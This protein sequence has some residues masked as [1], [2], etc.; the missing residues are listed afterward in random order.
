VVSGGDQVGGLAGTNSG[1]S[2]QTSYSTGF[3]SGTT[4]VG[5]LIGS[6]YSSVVSSYWNS[7]TSG[8]SSG[9]GSDSQSQSANVT[10]RTTAQLQNGSVPSGFSS[11]WGAGTGLYPYLLWQFAAGTTPQ[12]VSGTAHL[13]DNSPLVGARVTGAV[14]GTAMPY[15]ASTGANGYYY[16]VVPQGS[17][18]SGSGVFTAIVGNTVKA[19]AFAQGFSGSVQNLELY[20][21]QLRIKTNATALSDVASGLATAAGNLSGSDLVFTT[22]G[23]VLTPKSNTSLIVRASND[24]A[25]DQN[26]V[27][28]ST[29]EVFADNALTIAA[30]GS[31]TSQYDVI[32]LVAGTTFTN[33]SGADAL[34]TPY[35][36]WLIYSN[37]PAADTRGG[38][39]YAFKQYDAVYGVT[40]VAQATGNGVLY[41]VTPGTVTVALAGVTKSYDG[42]VDAVLAPANF[43]TTG[44][45]D[46]D[47][48][49]FT[50]GSAVYS[51]KNAATGLNVTATGVALTGISDG[52]ATVY[53]Y[54]FTPPGT[55]N[56]AGT[57][58]PASI[59]VT[60][61][62][63]TSAHGASPGNPG[64][65][66]S[67]LQGGEGVQALT[68]LSNT[69]G[70]TSAT[71]WQ[72]SPYSLAVIGTLTNPNYTIAARVG[73]TW[74]VTP[75][76]GF[77]SAIVASTV[78][79]S[80][81]NSPSN[82]STE[83]STDPTA[84][85]TGGIPFTGSGPSTTPG[86]VGGDGAFYVDKRFGL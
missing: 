58:T 46:G 43:S 40:V 38:L 56:G 70:I 33:N 57:I 16:F 54:T 81:M 83:N 29:A 73:G 31:V 85:L 59:T 72:D 82:S 37:D 71:R 9:M 4:N 1:G 20:E 39:V 63:G 49:A 68:G 28:W 45:I 50:Y 53:G 30:S 21:N 78:T 79:K 34:T 48:F 41:S 44:A 60:A 47:V 12:S 26:L 17:I 19:N 14:N 77:N 23:G 7:E 6:N 11:A 24:F 2:V 65:T 36:R 76:L 13:A 35:G 52:A 62:S 10:A 51:D 42:N 8:Q 75:P 18:G 22:P 80:M 3:V 15:G 61:L 55:L 27:V 84:M 66:A 74:I 25:I 64:L 5:G 86:S 67:G 32:T 69:F